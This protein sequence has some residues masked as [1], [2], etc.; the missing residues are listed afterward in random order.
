MC[1][2]RQAYGAEGDARRGDEDGFPATNSVAQP[3]G[4]YLESAGNGEAD[5]AIGCNRSIGARH[6]VDQKRNQK[7]DRAPIAGGEIPDAQEKADFFA[8]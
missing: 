1:G 7:S 8:A 2:K 5:G 3:T 4:E 6:A